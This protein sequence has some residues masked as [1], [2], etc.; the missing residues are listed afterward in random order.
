MQYAVIHIIIS[1]FI[2]NLLKLLY[3]IIMSKYTY[4][5]SG[6][7]TCKEHEQRGVDVVGLDCFRG[8]ATMFPVLK[9]IRVA[10]EGHVR[11]LHILYRTHAFA[12]LALHIFFHVFP[13]FPLPSSAVFCPRPCRR[14]RC[15]T[16]AR[17]RR[18]HLRRSLHSFLFVPVDLHLDRTSSGLMASFK[19]RFEVSSPPHL[20]V[21]PA[22]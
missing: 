11:A 6:V 2:V 16:C 15:W 7:D 19:L 3:K 12:L 13:F 22:W 4:S 5:K 21:M 9:E 20:S 18:L 8:T 17:R 1:W 10:V 14:R